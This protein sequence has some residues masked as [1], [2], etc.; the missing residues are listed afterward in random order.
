M[1]AIVFTESGVSALR[2]CCTAAFLGTDVVESLP[3]LTA[4]NVEAMS[5]TARTMKSQRTRSITVSLDIL[6]TCVQKTSNG[7]PLGIRWSVGFGSERGAMKIEVISLISIASNN[8]PTWS[9]ILISRIIRIGPQAPFC[10]LG[11]VLPS[12]VRGRPTG[13]LEPVMVSCGV[14]GLARWS[15]PC[16]TVWA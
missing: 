11:A 9:C 6:D 14:S 1:S 15:S 10:G 4:I 5:P 8:L 13:L 16:S 2:S 3:K 7:F 12:E